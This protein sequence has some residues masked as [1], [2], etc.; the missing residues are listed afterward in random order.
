MVAL[1]STI[2]FVTKQNL[3]DLRGCAGMLHKKRHRWPWIPAEFGDGLSDPQRPDS[4]DLQSGL[5]REHPIFQSRTLAEAWPTKPVCLRLN[6]WTSNLRA[7]PLTFPNLTV[8]SGC[9]CPSVCHNR[10]VK[11]PACR[12]HRRAVRL[13]HALADRIA[14]HAVN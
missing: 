3:L 5:S 13:S 2:S 10:R 12:N 6:P 9:L 14:V 4:P 1:H 7:R 8:L 11:A